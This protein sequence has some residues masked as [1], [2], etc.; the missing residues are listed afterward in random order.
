MIG[1]VVSVAFRVNGLEKL[2]ASRSDAAEA[3][4]ATLESQPLPAAEDGE[5]VVRI[6]DRSDYRIK[7][8]YRCAEDEF[9]KQNLDRCEQ[10]SSDVAEAVRDSVKDEIRRDSESRDDDTSLAPVIVAART[11]QS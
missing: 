6:Q 2:A 4:T 5:A 11:Q 7:L 10:L 8:H 3:P 1:L 9:R